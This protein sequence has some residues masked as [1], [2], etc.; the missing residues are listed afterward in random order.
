MVTV[1]IS[2]NFASRK[3]HEEKPYSKYVEL[4]TEIQDVQ[5]RCN[6]LLDVMSKTRV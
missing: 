2:F 1:S 3:S 5:F 6:S 4:E